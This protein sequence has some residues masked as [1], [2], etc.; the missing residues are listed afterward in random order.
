[1]L[2]C[3]CVMAVAAVALHRRVVGC[4]S[5]SS[6]LAA[7]A[8]ST[9]YRVGD[10]VGCCAASSVCQCVWAPT[11]LAGFCCLVVRLARR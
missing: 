4:R 1:M 5:C 6:I 10:R 11:H 3:M 8:T 2:L 9:S 7:A